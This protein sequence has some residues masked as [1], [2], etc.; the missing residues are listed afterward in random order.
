MD[1]PLISII[2]PVY[3]VEDYL[4]QCVES[5]VG[6]TYQNIEIILVDDGSPDRCPQIVDEWAQRDSRIRPVHKQNGGQSSARNLGMELAKGQYIT[7]I[8]SDDWVAPEYC[9]RLYETMTACNAQ[10][11]VGS[12]SRMVGK[13]AHPAQYFRPSE[14]QHVACPPNEAVHYFVEC[15]NAVWGKMYKAELLEN[16]KFPEGR[17]AEEYGFQLKALQ[18]ATT[19]G[20]CN[21]HI[22]HYRIRGNSD[23]H[24]I[25]PKYLLDNIQA[26]DEAYYTCMEHFP[27][28]T[29][30][31]LQRL[32]ALLYEF[33]AAKAYGK[34]TEQ[35]NPGV[36]EHALQTVGGL[37]LMS[38][39]M[40]TPLAT[41]F[42]VYNQFYPYL[43]KEEKR[44]LQGDYR[45]IFLFRDAQQYGWMF[46]IKY[47][48]SYISLE[49]MRRVSKRRSAG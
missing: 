34:E 28:E 8:D 33:L 32:S 23:A 7:F 43:T 10:I 15:S 40:E 9:Q 25:K 14:N 6:Q 29:S 38:K 41:I 3:G 21:S 20:F 48:P 1:Q 49:L 11:A 26:L 36:L 31:C 22:Y 17:L 24:S 18:K 5:I 44:K 47:L 46:W 19:V 39:Q 30:F 16:I 42:Y 2:L 13:K 37:Q 4:E 27:E 45:N 35:Q 12:Y